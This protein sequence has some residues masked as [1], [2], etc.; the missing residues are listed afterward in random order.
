MPVRRSLR[1]V[2]RV[3]R[4]GLPLWVWLA[5]L[6]AVV[7]PALAAPVAD[8]VT[9]SQKQAALEYLDAVASGDPQAMAQAI[10]P[11]ELLALRLR[12][13]GLM[14]EESDGTTTWHRNPCW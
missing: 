3:A 2:A 6:L 9:Q 14:R 5:L 12:L 1:P 7:V 4:G 8:K 11:D 13:L 10:H